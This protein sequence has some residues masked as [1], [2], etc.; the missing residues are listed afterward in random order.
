MANS[1]AKRKS[2]KKY[3]SGTPTTAAINIRAAQ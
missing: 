2:A 1:D 3:N